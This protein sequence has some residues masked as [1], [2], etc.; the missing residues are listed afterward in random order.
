MTYPGIDRSELL[1]EAAGD[2]PAR[3]AELMQATVSPD[4]R[5]AAALIIYNTRDAPYEAQAFFFRDED[6][7]WAL[8]GEAYGLGP[9]EYFI[10]DIGFPFIVGVAPRRARS[11]QIATGTQAATHPVVE[12]YFF[13]VAWH[14]PVTE[15]AAESDAYVPRLV[16]FT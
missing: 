5:F 15:D 7:E 3:W 10:G 2:V 1:R 14:T 16:G 13:A 8:A 6:D 9:G 4:G 12:G 11:V